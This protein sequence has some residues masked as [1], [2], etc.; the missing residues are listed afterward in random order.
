MR[1][2]VKEVATILN[3]DEATVQ[4]I[5][6]HYFKSLYTAITKVKYKEIDSFE[7]VKTNATIPGLGKFCVSA[8]IKERFNKRKNRKNAREN[9]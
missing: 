7:G 1:E 9:S 3:L 8:Y 4:S 5:V 6:D 2:L